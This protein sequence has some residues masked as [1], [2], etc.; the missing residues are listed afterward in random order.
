MFTP[1]PAHSQSTEFHVEEASISELHRAIQKGQVTCKD[2]VQAGGSAEARRP[3]FSA[4]SV[5]SG[6]FQNEIGDDLR[7]GVLVLGAQSYEAFD[8]QLK[9]LLR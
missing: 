9:A 8:A 3:V 5:D 6:T 1:A 2:V 7:D 4:C